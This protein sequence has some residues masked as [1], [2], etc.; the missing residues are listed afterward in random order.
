MPVTALAPQASASA[1]SATFARGTDPFNRTASIRQA[2]R[3]L[4]P[5]PSP[6]RSRRVRP[7]RLGE[8][9]DD[10]GHLEGLSHPADSLALEPLGQADGAAADE[11]ERDV[12]RA[13]AQ[14]LDGAAHVVGDGREVDERRVVALG[15]AQR[16]ARP[17]CAR[18]RPGA[19]RAPSADSSSAA[20]SASSSTTSTRVP[21]ST[22]GRGA[23]TGARGEGRLDARPA[24]AEARARAEPRSRARAR[25]R[26]RPRAPRRARAAAPRRPRPRG[27]TRRRRRTAP[28]PRARPGPRP[29]PR[30]IADRR[31]GLRLDVDLA[32]ARRPGERVEQDVG[33]HLRRVA[34]QRACARPGVAAAHDERRRPRAAPRPRAP[35][36]PRPTTAS[37]GSSR[38]STTA[39][40]ADGAPREVAR[41]RARAPR[42]WR[43]R[44]RPAR[45]SARGRARLGHPPE[46]DGERVGHVVERAGHVAVRIARRGGSLQRA[47]GR[48]SSDSR[49]TPGS[50]DIAAGAVTFQRRHGSTDACGTR[51]GSVGRHRARSPPRPPRPRARRAPCAPP[52]A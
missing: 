10:L 8:R 22:A 1:N 45:A 26:P 35:R 47:R 11:D 25:A 17:P 28:A 33:Q 37:S 48:D 13:R 12:G 14:R 5:G 39:C 4:A 32:A 51:R 31:V 50:Y 34:R 21:A 36:P 52:P 42:R 9:G 18:R 44:A 19:P 3:T 16:R 7:S 6:G 38:S 15:R 24:Q 29:A 46:Q 40:G 30:P 43:A 2:R 20:T 27:S 23:E 41:R 49:G